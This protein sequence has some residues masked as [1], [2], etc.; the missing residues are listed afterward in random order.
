[1][2]RYHNLSRESSTYN[3]GIGPA[4][5]RVALRRN[6]SAVANLVGI[7]MFS[8]SLA[9]MSVGN[10]YLSKKWPYKRMNLK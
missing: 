8:V 6:T 4:L 1:M 10:K 3:E 2:E 9:Q 5:I 7:R